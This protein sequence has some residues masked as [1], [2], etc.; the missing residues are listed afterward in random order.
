MGV[1]GEVPGTGFLKAGGFRDEGRSEM[2]LE[3]AE[4]AAGGDSMEA[5]GV[6]KEGGGCR[7]HGGVE[8]EMEEAV[9]GDAGS[10][11]TGERANTVA[12]DG[13]GEGDAVSSMGGVAGDAPAVESL[14]EVG[15]MVK[16]GGSR[17]L[18]KACAAAASGSS[19]GGGR[20]GRRGFLNAGK[21]Q[22]VEGV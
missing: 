18:N 3:V 5:V 2:F 21:G 15:G 10:I 20:Q 22:A 8:L 1:V 6:G 19:I 13:D 14:L 12:G 9:A 11:I 17:V 16:D 7:V 4:G